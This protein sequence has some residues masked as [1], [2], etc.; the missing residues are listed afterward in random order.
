MTCASLLLLFDCNDSGHVVHTPVC[1]HQAVWD[2]H[3][4]VILCSWEGDHA[5]RITLIWLHMPHMHIHSLVG[6]R[7]GDELPA[8]AHEESG[9]LFT[10]ET[11]LT[12][13]NLALHHPARPIG[14]EADMA[15]SRGT[16]SRQEFSSVRS[17]Q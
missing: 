8:F 3:S 7:A 16:C 2:P 5:S 14:H 6:L 1:C 13:K 12:K 4:A 9:T 15:R 11:V 10:L 17:V